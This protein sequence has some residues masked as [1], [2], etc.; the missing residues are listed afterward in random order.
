M[1][2]KHVCTE[3]F[4]FAYMF[5]TGPVLVSPQAIPDPQNLALKAIYDGQVVQDGNT[6]YETSV[7]LLNNF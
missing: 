2:C 1:H 6:R 5:M 4:S 3:K 7:P